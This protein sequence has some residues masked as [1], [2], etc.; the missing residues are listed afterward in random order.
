MKKII[1]WILVIIWSVMIF[2]LSSEPATTSDETSGRFGQ[3]I[4]RMAISL[5]IIDIPVS[6]DGD[7]FIYEMADK[8][9]HFVRKTAHFTIY[10]ILGILSFM[11]A[12]CY[13]NRKKAILYALIFCLLYA[14]SDEIHQ[15]FVP[16]RSGEIRDVLIDF[17]G[18][19]LGIIILTFISKIK[20]VSGNA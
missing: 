3:M 15:L 1:L 9:N 2:C 11:L 17:S 6:T 5:N 10:L 19:L 16:G 7:I 13:E 14:I 18:S 8:I 12:E 20:R 4:I